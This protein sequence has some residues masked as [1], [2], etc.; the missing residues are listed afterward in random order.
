MS[1]Q[2][3]RSRIHTSDGGAVAR[4]RQA[5]RDAKA[6][7]ALVAKMAEMQVR[8]ADHEARIRGVEAAKHKLQGACLLLG[9]ISASGWLGVLLT[10]R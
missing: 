3:P 6:R 10:H 5:N 9:A 7:D 8:V 4:A 2:R 1:A